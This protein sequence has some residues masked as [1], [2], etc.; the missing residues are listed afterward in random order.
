LLNS[1]SGSEQLYIS[2]TLI[3]GSDE[4]R[5]LTW[6]SPSPSV[7][8]PLPERF[9]DVDYGVMPSSTQQVIEDVVGL[10]LCPTS[11]WQ[12]DP[13]LSQEYLCLV[14]EDHV[15]VD[16]QSPGVS[17]LSLRQTPAQNEPLLHTE[18]GRSLVDSLSA[19]YAGLSLLFKCE[20]HLVFCSVS[21]HFSLVATIMPTP[22]N[23]DEY[24][25]DLK[26]QT[27]NLID[28]HLEGFKDFGFCPM[29]GRL[30]HFGPDLEL[31]I[32]DYLEKPGN[33]L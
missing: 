19:G 33:L 11:I 32:R 28:G 10:F 8:K 1:D 6:E 27:A 26:L 20:D 29:S 15:D 13:S 25:P 14:M 4:N 21:N 22:G 18:H 16:G 7:F 30:V 3:V 2:D 5:L 17:L 23:A 12:R 9:Q 31:Y 24:H